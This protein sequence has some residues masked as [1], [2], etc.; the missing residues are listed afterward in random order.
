MWDIIAAPL[1]SSRRAAALTLPFCWKFA[2]AHENMFCLSL[3]TTRFFRYL[4]PGLT[5]IVSSAPQLADA[6]ILH[7]RS[8][9]QHGP[10][11]A[12]QAPA[13]SPDAMV[14]GVLTSATAGSYSFRTIGT[15]SMT[16]VAPEEP[17]IIPESTHQ[18]YV[19]P[20]HII[21]EP[22]ALCAASAGPA[23]A[24]SPDASSSPGPGAAVLELMGQIQRS[25][26]AVD[27]RM[28][29]SHHAE[30]VDH[31]A[32]VAAMTRLTQVRGD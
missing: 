3:Q 7:Q 10:S 28:V 12:Q 11:Q 2:L 17:S 18:V 15:T 22:S 19:P 24:S 4:A 25:R 30:A 32:L 29:L 20:E 14:L 13:Q 26:S 27:L 9:V 5:A 21:S 1:A 6:I 23:S 16:A 8:A 31:L